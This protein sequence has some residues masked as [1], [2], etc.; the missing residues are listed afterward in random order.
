MMGD[1]NDPASEIASGKCIR[2]NEF[3]SKRKRGNGARGRGGRR[4]SGRREG[5]RKKY[6]LAED[7]EGD[8]DE[9]N[10]EE[11]EEEEDPYAHYM[12]HVDEDTGYLV[13]RYQPGGSA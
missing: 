11:E 6:Y 9:K 13:R 1:A 12:D 10:E 5:A 7:S 2:R 4:D 8:Q 3:Q